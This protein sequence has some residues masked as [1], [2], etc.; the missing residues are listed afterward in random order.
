MM[1]NLRSY[2][3]VCIYIFFHFTYCLYHVIHL[4]S[5]VTL[6]EICMSIFYEEYSSVTC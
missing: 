6:G 1:Y 3:H 2:M 4:N 5:C